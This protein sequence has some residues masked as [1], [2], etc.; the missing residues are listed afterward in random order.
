MYKASTNPGIS[1]DTLVGQAM[2]NGEYAGRDGE[3]YNKE[4]FL[5]DLSSYL[6]HVN[7]QLTENKKIPLSGIFWNYSCSYPEKQK[8]LN[9]LIILVSDESD[10]RTV[11]N[12]IKQ[13]L[14]EFARGQDYQ[15]F[16]KTLT[17]A[18]LKHGA[19]LEKEFPTQAGEKGIELKLK[20]E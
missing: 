7:E 13:G 11:L 14:R 9:E 10:G 1:Y 6:Q 3:Y 19:R 15:S 18:L 2:P 17:V 4:K 12:K 8:Y 20:S 5:E 16:N